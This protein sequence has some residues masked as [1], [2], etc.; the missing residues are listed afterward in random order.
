MPCH[1][2][3]TSLMD[4]NPNTLPILPILFNQVSTGG[5][6]GTHLTGK[7]PLLFSLKGAET[8][9]GQ[10]HC[11][12]LWRTGRKSHIFPARYSVH[13]AFW[14]TP[15]CWLCL[16][17]DMLG[18]RLLLVGVPSYSCLLHHGLPGILRWQHDLRVSLRASHPRGHCRNS[19]PG[20]K[21]TPIP[22]ALTPAFC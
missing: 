3:Q 12:S 19:H 16:C 22:R 21:T 2:W 4:L 18:S 14:H 13:A 9:E 8:R 20:I 1:L 7:L 5:S 6:R 17:H 10:A 15:A 11:M